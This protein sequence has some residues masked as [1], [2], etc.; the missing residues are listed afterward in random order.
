MPTR[1]EL[2]DIGTKSLQTGAFTGVLGAAFGAG[3]GIMRA[4]PPGLFALIAGIQWF[5]LGS[6][7]M[8]K[9]LKT[10]VNKTPPRSNTPTSFQESSLACLGRRREPDPV[11]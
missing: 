7:F 8:G 4:A 1:D 6:S 5:A 11:G 2:F 10:Q 3:S 9:Q